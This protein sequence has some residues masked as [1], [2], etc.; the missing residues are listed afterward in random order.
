M[1]PGIVFQ[2]DDRISGENIAFFL[3]KPRKKEIIMKVD[4]G[5]CLSCIN[6]LD[7]TYK[8][9]PERPILQCEEFDGFESLPRET[10]IKNISFTS[11]SNFRLG[12]E[13]NELSNYKGL[14]GTCE[15]RD[16]CTFPK[17]EG[18]VWHCEEYR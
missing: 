16:A 10:P 13:E 5:L 2:P 3:V 12:I 1:P 6:A 14:C 7:C 17:L 11:A 4:R 9:D 18:G 8:K 15:D